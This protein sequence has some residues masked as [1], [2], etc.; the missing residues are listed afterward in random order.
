M[1]LLNIALVFGKTTLQ[2]YDGGFWPLIF[3]GT[4]K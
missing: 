2:T 4:I 1:F 3:Q